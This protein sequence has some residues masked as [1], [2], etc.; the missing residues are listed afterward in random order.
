MSS[1][2]IDLGQLQDNLSKAKAGLTSSRTLSASADRKV[3]LAQAA[4][5]KAKARVRE[6]EAAVAQARQALLEGARTTASN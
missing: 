3:E 6:N 2:A 5:D 4:A 1:K